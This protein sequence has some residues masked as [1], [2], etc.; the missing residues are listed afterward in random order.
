MTDFPELDAEVERLKSFVREHL[1][2]RVSEI[3]ARLTELES[4]LTVSE[5]RR[6]WSERRFLLSETQLGELTEERDTVKDQ[7]LI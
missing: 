5:E 2:Q 6:S 3:Q 7:G 4:G 1:D